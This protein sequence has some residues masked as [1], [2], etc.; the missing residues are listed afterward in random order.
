MILTCVE[1]RCRSQIPTTAALVE[2]EPVP[3]GDIDA[4]YRFYVKCTACKTL[5]MLD[6]ALPLPPAIETVVKQRY[7]AGLP[8]ET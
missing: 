7:L 6:N 8:M 2:Y 1:D 5:N 3:A 4:P